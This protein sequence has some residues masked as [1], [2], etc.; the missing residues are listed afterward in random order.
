MSI[1]IAT[2]SF[3]SAFDANGNPLAGGKVY[4]YLAGTLT[5]RATYTDQGGLTPNANP[6]ILDSAGRADI[7]LD[8]SASYK[9]IVKDSADNTIKTTDNVAPFST[10]AGLSV[11]GTIA[12]NTL[13]GNNTGS[14]AVPSALTVAQV[15]AMIGSS[16]PY[17]SISGFL[18]SSIAG[19]STTATLT[20]SAGQAA[21][22]T[23]VSLFAK[24]TTTAWAV[25]NGNAANGYSGGTTLP[26]SS[27]IHFYVIALPADTSWTATFA[28]T[29]L[30]PTLPGSYT[31]Y[32]RVFSITTTGAGALIP[33]TA[34]EVYGGGVEA[35]LTAQAMDVQV[36]NLGNSA[37]T[38]YTLTSVPTGVRMMPLFRASGDSTSY[39]ILT[40][41][42]ETDVAPSTSY[43]TVPMFDVQN[44]VSVANTLIPATSFITNT[45]SQ[46][47]ARS[48]SGTSN[49]LN[50][51]TRG[52]IDFRR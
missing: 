11:L 9:F 28:S 25:T 45:S 1:V 31:K 38:L 19:T 20:F 18:P 10:A 23:N 41:P 29:S 7:W 39:T 16:F 26:N 22:S 46:I 37:R 3:Y 8:D 34:T 36:T 44:V 12:A 21:D 14:A 32:R 17:N 40:S 49:A 24:A 6:V 13:V 35:T 50:I 2:P 43:T 48:S 15:Q 51:V 5:P 47:G 52:W 42:H 30:T 27:T 33:Y 4:T